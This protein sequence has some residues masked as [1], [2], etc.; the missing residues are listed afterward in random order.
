VLHIGE[1]T[2][3][4]VVVTRSD[5]DAHVPHWHGQTVLEHG[6]RMDA[7]DAQPNQTVAVDMVP[8]DAGIWLFHCHVS[9]HLAHG[10]E[11]RYTVVR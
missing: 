4:Y 2:R 3:W 6:M 10:M 11:A 5:F 8:D 9:V 7:I 1:R